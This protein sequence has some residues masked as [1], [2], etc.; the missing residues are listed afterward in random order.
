[1]ITGKYIA[2][3][4]YKRKWQVLSEK[5]SIHL[6]NVTDYLE[7]LDWFLVV[8]IFLFNNFIDI[9]F[10]NNKTINELKLKGLVQVCFFRLRISFT[11]Q[12]QV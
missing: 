11:W 3:E 2:L 7:R 10:S 5:N 9:I 6:S 4:E 1:M 12:I 8:K